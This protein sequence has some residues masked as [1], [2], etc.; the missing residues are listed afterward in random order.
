MQES[1]GGAFIES[2]QDVEGG[3]RQMKEAL[4]QFIH[5]HYTE[6]L[7]VLPMALLL[8]G[9]LIAVGIDAYLQKRKKQI[10]LMICVLVFSLNMQNLVDHLLTVG[11]PAIMLRRA[12]DIYGYSIRPLILLLFLH[13]VSPKKPGRALWILIVVNAA[14]H[15]T[16][17]FTDICFTINGDNK[18][19]GGWP[20]LKNSCLILLGLL[21]FSTFRDY[22]PSKRKESWIPI[23]SVFILL[24]ALVLDGSVAETPQPSAS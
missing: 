16:A 10:M 17:L 24:L 13:I 12:V 5:G 15:L 6:M 21:V 1:G 18:F 9:L 22:H 8:V 2:K 3:E 14:I 7:A 20:V 4:Y 23:F 19:Q 11:K